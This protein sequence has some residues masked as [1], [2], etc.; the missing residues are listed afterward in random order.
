MAVYQKILWTIAFSAFY[1]IAGVRFVRWT[2]TTTYMTPNGDSVQN[3]LMPLVTP[4]IALLI[5]A[6]GGYLIYKVWKE[7]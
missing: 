2:A 6:P 7:T 5:S 4:F 1:M 3:L